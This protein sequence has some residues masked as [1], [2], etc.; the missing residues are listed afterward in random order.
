MKQ[1]DLDRNYFEQIGLDSGALTLLGV[2]VHS[3]RDPGEYRGTVRRGKL[4]EASFYISADSNS[5]VAQVTIDLASLI[6]GVDDE[7]DECCKEENKNRF[8]VNPKGYVLF[9]VSRGS[10]GYNVNIRKAAEDQKTPVYNSS[11]LEEGDIF[12]GIIVRPGRYSLTNPASRTRGE[13]V[14]SY[15]V[16]GKTAYRPPAPVN[17]ECTGE[18]FKP[19]RIELQ[20]GQGLHC[21]VR[22][23]SRLKIDL[24]EPDDGPGR[25]R[26]RFKRGFRKRSLLTS[27][28]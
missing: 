3:M 7:N 18:G 28:E 11:Q 26:E 15:P 9:R 8:V 20:P 4:P 19:E 23:P 27:K 16:I 10:G 12:S 2:I 5:P 25:E 14:V 17:V 13:I 24:V 6:P 21:Q 1:F 22:V